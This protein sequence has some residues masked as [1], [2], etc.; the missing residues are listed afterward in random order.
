MKQIP[1]GIREIRTQNNKIRDEKGHI[2][3]DTNEIQRFI[4]KGFKFFNSKRLENVD[5]MN[6]FL[7]RDR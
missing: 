7:E 6:K 1:T 3:G 5:E 4:R 2:I